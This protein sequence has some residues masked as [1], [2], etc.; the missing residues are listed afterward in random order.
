MG[1]TEATIALS[2][3]DTSIPCRFPIP[4]MHQTSL[5]PQQT[6]KSG[7]LDKF[8]QGQDS[9]H[10]MG[11]PSIFPICVCFQPSRRQAQ[12][13]ESPQEEKERVTSQLHFSCRKENHWAMPSR[14]LRA[15]SDSSSYLERQA[16]EGSSVL[17]LDTTES[18]VRWKS[19]YSVYELERRAINRRK[20]RG[21]TRYVALWVWSITI[22]V[23]SCVSRCPVRW[24]RGR[25]GKS[26]STSKRYTRSPQSN[27]VSEVLKGRNCFRCS[28][29]EGPQSG[30]GLLRFH[31]KIVMWYTPHLLEGTRETAQH[32]KEVG[33]TKS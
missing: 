17:A 20:T 25:K 18:S 3:G 7:S 30:R 14:V 28:C 15:S 24:I 9:A 4:E 23:P 2:S 31:K 26:F 27:R 21:C 19:S 5:A 12:V 11:R 33:K 29:C 6:R 13:I 1:D 22:V 16:I 8:R 10:H 32:R